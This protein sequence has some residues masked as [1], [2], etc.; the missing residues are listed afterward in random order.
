MAVNKS[1]RKLLSNKYLLWTVTGVTTLMLL[2]FLAS[3]NGDAAA[4]MVMTGLIVSFFTRNMI[5]ILATALG[6]GMIYSGSRVEE[7]KQKGYAYREGFEGQK[8]EEPA[9][10][11]QKKPV[12]GQPVAGQPVAR[13]P[14]D[15]A[16]GP[17][18]GGE[19]VKA[20]IANLEE[21][22][23]AGSVDTMSQ[24]TKNL[25]DQQNAL[26]QKLETI[27]PLVKQGMGMLDKVGGTDGINKM[28]ET[29]ERFTPQGGGDKI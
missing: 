24:T 14:G 15:S 23:G 2:G 16:P 4:F 17:L 19:S 25:L 21:I 18:Q 8:E 28:L 26:G 5:I 11:P 3:D 1:V 20:T 9:E 7:D 12:A 22:L 6:L 29:L 13:Q 27:L 10:I